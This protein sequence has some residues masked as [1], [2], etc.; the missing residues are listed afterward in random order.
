M[1]EGD[2]MLHWLLGTIGYLLLII[3]SILLYFHK[4]KGKKNIP[5][6]IASLFIVSLSCIG[7]HE[8]NIETRTKLINTVNELSTQIAK[9][10]EAKEEYILSFYESLNGLGIDK[11]MITDLQ[12]PHEN[13]DYGDIVRVKVDLKEPPNTIFSYLSYWL[14]QYNRS[15]TFY[16]E[17]IVN[18][19][20]RTT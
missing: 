4:K 19:L 12:Y 15:L 10:G 17:N 5:Y 16:G 20:S 9:E 13:L 1:K 8:S 2:S 14:F 18:I 7:L 11:E 6:R 3:T